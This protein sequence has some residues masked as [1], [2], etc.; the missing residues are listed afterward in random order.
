MPGCGPLAGDHRHALG[1]PAQD[2]I[3]RAQLTASLGRLWSYISNL[4][5]E[6]YGVNGRGFDFSARAV[7]PGA[8]K[9]LRDS[10]VVVSDDET[11]AVNTR[12]VGSPIAD[13]SRLVELQSGEAVADPD[14]RR[15]W[16]FLAHCDPSD[17]SVLTAIRK[18]GAKLGDD[19]AQ[20]ISELLGPLHLGGSVVRFEVVY[21][22][23][24]V[25]PVIAPSQFSS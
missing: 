15:V 19:R 4:V 14:Q 8:L 24:Y 17:L 6:R 3:P 9:A 1:W 22:V 11:P 21:G 12:G 16:S 13:G 2:H 23:R 5:R 10:V 20:S 18:V 7:E 25:N